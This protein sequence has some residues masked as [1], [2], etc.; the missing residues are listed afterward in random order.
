MAK[1]N[2]EKSTIYHCSFQLNSEHVEA[3]RWP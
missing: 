2:W 3:E 1:K